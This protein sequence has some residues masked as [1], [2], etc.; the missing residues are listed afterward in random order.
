[1]KKRVFVI[2]GNSL[3]H[4]AFHAITPLINKE[5]QA[6]HAV[7][8]FL[9]MLLRLIK[10]ENPDGI[11]VAFDIGKTFR[12]KMYRE[13][14][15]KRK[16]TDKDLSSQ[17]PILK[18]ILKYMKIPVLAVEG[19]EADDILGA[20]ACKGKAAGD[21]IYVVT[22]DKDSLQ[23][24]NNDVTVYLTKKGLSQIEKLDILTLKETFGLDPFQI[25]D[26]KGLQGDV[27]DNIKGVPGIGKKTALKLITTYGN[28]EEIYKHLDDLGGR[29]KE[30]LIK[31]KEEAF[32]C[33][34]LATIHC[35][36][37]IFYDAYPFDLTLSNKK[38]L[39]KL[40]LALEFKSLLS[41]FEIENIKD[42]KSMISIIKPVVHY[43][44]N[45]FIEDLERLEG[46]NWT[47]YLELNESQEISLCSIYNGEKPITLKESFPMPNVTKSIASCLF[48]KSG[49]FI[50][51]NSKPLFHLLL[52]EFK[53][54]DSFR[55]D[56]IK[57]MAYIAHSKKIYNIDSFMSDFMG[58]KVDKDYYTQNLWYIYKVVKKQLGEKNVLHIYDNIEKPLLSILCRIE[59]HGIVID[60]EALKKMES[61]IKKKIKSLT[62]DI[63]I[64][65]GEEF[66]INSSQQ[67]GEILFKKLELSP[68]KKN[69]TGYSTNQEILG[70]LEYK[71]PI[72]KLLLEY[73][74]VTKLF[75]TYIKG[76]LI[77]ADKDRVIHTTYNQT[78]VATGRLSSENPNLQNIPIRMKEGR[79]IRKA[80]VPVNTKNYFLSA[81]YSQIE[82]RVLAHISGDKNL[83]SAF[84][85]GEDIHIKTASEIFGVPI[86]EV[87]KDMR[88]KAKAVN[89]GIVYGISDFG[90]SR[91]LDISIEES[92]LYIEK[93]FS[94]YPGVR[95]WI[96]EM[97]IEARK[98]LKVN[99]LA[100]RYRLLPDLKSSNYTVRSGAERMAINM[101]IQGTAADLIKIAMIYINDALITEALE[102]VI[103]LQVHDELIFEVPEKEIDRMK[104]LV[105]D[106][107]SNAMKLDVPLEMD[108]KIGKNWYDMNEL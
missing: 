42:E 45:A 39:R 97:L 18:N 75:N 20:V 104:V 82:L 54:I 21:H 57:L 34:D 53:N 95:R 38:A 98:T 44:A 63:F 8:G 46:E 25:I 105:V 91:D 78:V 17:F 35:D 65:A 85:N 48:R 5:G 67:L 19:F 102:S 41:E 51:F 71:H 73:R 68:F 79:L 28:L 84:L 47:L 86:N 50:S 87:T 80:F 52:A 22:G 43:E 4:R 27:S 37:P 12:H 55:F 58:T 31:Y 83:Q 69:K 93:Y 11:A 59:H 64:L 36:I 108:I 100:G 29:L 32:F 107:M 62:E 13:Y 106:K 7:Y 94:R 90:L 101:P 1:M 96:D 26:M 89:F 81:D 24:I 15:A 76:L 61:E 23:L 66:N 92:G 70:K 16:K 33:R 6:T 14:K 88:R 49:N 10:D 103:V 3:I 77:L 40:F 30:N 60:Y 99:T 9:K 74:K 2:D 56:D 72:I